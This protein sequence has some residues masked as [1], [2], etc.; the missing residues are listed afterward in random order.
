MTKITQIDITLEKALLKNFLKREVYETYIE[1]VDFKRL[2]PNT[3]LLLTDYD[4]YY[5]LYPEASLIDLGVF[6]THFAQDWHNKDIE[7]SDLEYYRDAVFPAIA[8]CEEIEAEKCLLGLMQKT[9]ESQIQSIGTDVNKL[10]ECIEAHEAEIARFNKKEVNKSLKTATMIELEDMDKSKGIPWFLPSL[11]RN[12]VSL[13][14]GQFV[15]VSADWGTGKSA[16]V[17]S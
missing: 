4:A 16:F 3:K 14:K 12:L 8:A 7:Q 11:R 15:V 10:R 6:Y 5:K 9:F 2:L 13:V 1:A 17:L